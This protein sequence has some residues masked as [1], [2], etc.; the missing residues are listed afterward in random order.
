MKKKHCT[1]IGSHRVRTTVGMLI[2]DNLCLQVSYRILR[3]L[4]DRL[5]YTDLNGFLLQWFVEYAVLRAGS[6]LFGIFYL[7]FLMIPF[8]RFFVNLML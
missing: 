3:M 5:F 1:P 2:Q 8:Y 7:L 4:P 6:K